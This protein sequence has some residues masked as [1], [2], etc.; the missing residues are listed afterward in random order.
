M[1][2]HDILITSGDFADA[3][4]VRTSVSNHRFVWYASGTERPAGRINLLHTLPASMEIYDQLQQ[5]R[6]GQS[7]TIS[8]WEIQDIQL[9]ENGRTITTWKDSG[10]NSL[11]VDAVVIEP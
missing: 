1:L 10:C 11:L 8:G 2:S 3:G 7:V 6:K 4:M 9:I 5:V